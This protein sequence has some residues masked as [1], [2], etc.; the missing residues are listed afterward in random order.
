MKALL[1]NL[2]GKTYGFIEKN[3]YLTLI[4][5]LITATEEFFLAKPVRAKTAP[6]IHDALNLKRLMIFAVLG[7]SP[8]AAASIY[9]FGWRSLTIIA[10]SYIFGGL[11][12]ITFAIVRKHQISE[13]FLVTA[14]LFPLTLPPTIPLW[15]V[16]VG[17]L[18]GVVFGKEVFG[19]TGKNI[20]NPALTGRVFLAI[21]FPVELTTRWVEPTREAI[22]ALNKYSIDVVT[23]ATALI[24]YRSTGAIADYYDLFIGRVAGGIGET[25]KILIIIGALFLF[26]TKVANWRSPVAFVGSAGLFSLIFSN[27]YPDI[28]APPLFQLL[29]GGLL[30]CAAFML[31]DPVTSPYTNS[32]KWIFGGL[33]GIITIIIRD[34]SGFVEGV[35][36]AIL[37]MN[38]FAP[39]ID[40]IVLMVKYRKAEA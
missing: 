28:F 12:E 16:A 20:F 23:S 38:I 27:I 25:S 37:F 31:T 17:I 36:F 2:F 34:L 10:V 21:T 30:F 14:L 8:C 29:S 4:T 19:G 7:I 13:G 40:Q 26:I 24:N 22:G 1:T 32:G 15:M 18:F 9:F 6:F 11:A 39:L 33:A 5:P 35:M 3:K